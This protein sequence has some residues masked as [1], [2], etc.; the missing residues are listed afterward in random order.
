MKFT[1]IRLSSALVALVITGG[2]PLN[3]A[4]IV[5]YS[6]G[7][8]QDTTIWNDLT[9]D[10][11]T[12]AAASGSGSAS[13]Q[14]P[15]QQS[16]FGLYSNTPFTT[17]VI[18]ASRF[19]IQNV[20]FQADVTLSSRLPIGGGPLLSFNGGAQNIAADYFANNGTEIR[21]IPLFG[22]LEYTGAAWQWDLS[23]YGNTITSV[24]I[25]NP[26]SSL[27]VVVGLRVDTAAAMTTPIPEPTVV[28]LTALAGGLAFLLRRRA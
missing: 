17:T 24:T 28:G 13:V 25:V 7:S 6:L 3:A 14:G 5:D 2:I 20:I 8:L 1:S 9:F 26:Y 11:P 23:G 27:G 4:L 15:G 21:S 12:M 19:D 18:Q 16:S 10:N 22:P